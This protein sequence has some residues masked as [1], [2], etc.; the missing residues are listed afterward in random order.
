MEGSEEEREE[1]YSHLKCKICDGYF[2]KPKILPGCYHTFC[3]VCISQSTECITEQNH[4]SI[5]CEICNTITTTPSL[6]LLPNNSIVEK[7]LLN[8]KPSNNNKQVKLLSH[9][10]HCDIQ[11]CKDENKNASFYCEKCEANFCEGCWK[12]VHNGVLKKHSSLPVHQKNDK[13]YCSIHHKEMMFYCI[14]CDHLLC[15]A[16]FLNEHQNVSNNNDDNNN[17][18]N[19]IIDDNLKKEHKVISMEKASEILKEEFIKRSDLIL[20]NKMTIND[21]MKENKMKIEEIDMRIGKLKEEIEKLE[22]EKEIIVGKINEDEENSKQIEVSNKMIKDM[23]QSLPSIL[24]FQKNY[25]DK[26][27]SQISQVFQSLYSFPLSQI[28]EKDEHDDLR[29]LNAQ[30]IRGD[31]NHF[32]LSNNGKELRRK[33]VSHCGITVKKGISTGNFRWKVLY[34]PISQ[35]G[36]LLIAV[37]LNKPICSSTSSYCEQETFG[38]VI[39]STSSKNPGYYVIRGNNDS[40]RKLDLK[41]KSGEELEVVVDC[42]KAIFQLISSTFNHSISLPILK[43]NQDYYLHFNSSSA[44]FSIL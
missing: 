9:T 18:N 12:G 41:A 27:D 17:N 2:E 24:T 28:M 39:N 13:K 32:V 38:M 22:I 31:E 4:F 6:S 35:N 43:P 30:S 20:S 40:P 10:L 7:L 16:C 19:N 26:I 21:R 44:S 34:N 11:L 29:V 5:A 36:W 25:R 15:S 33:Q 42:E 1:I 3:L 14:P 23:I 37:Q 8:F